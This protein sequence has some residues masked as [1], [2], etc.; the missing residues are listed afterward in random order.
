MGILSASLA[1]P[2]LQ[3]IKLVTT[4]LWRPI[5]PYKVL[6]FVTLPLKPLESDLAVIIARQ[7]AQRPGLNSD[8]WYASINQYFEELDAKSRLQ[9]PLIKIDKIRQE[10]QFWFERRR[11]DITKSLPKDEVIEVFE[12]IC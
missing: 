3:I 8:N 2:T 9:T 11:Y 4:F 10:Y 12:Y 1:R 6:E 7:I 5:D